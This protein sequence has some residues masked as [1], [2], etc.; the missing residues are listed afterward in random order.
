MLGNN[1]CLCQYDQKGMGYI[2]LY[3]HIK[4]IEG[5]RSHVLLRRFKEIMQTRTDNETNHNNMRLI[6]FYS[7]RYFRRD[8]KH[9]VLGKWGASLRLL[10]LSVACQNRWHGQSVELYLSIPLKWLGSPRTHHNLHIPKTK[11]L[12]ESDLVIVWGTQSY[13]LDYHSVI[14]ESFQ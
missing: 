6:L 3:M 1:F 5:G 2:S 12:S 13:N 14:S 8:H 10:Q 9:K 11:N 7:E 4:V